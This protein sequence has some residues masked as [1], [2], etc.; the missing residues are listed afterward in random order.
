VALPL[1]RK[2]PLYLSYLFTGDNPLCRAFRTN[3]RA[4]NCIFAFMSISYKKDTRI[5]FSR[6]IQCFQIYGKLFYFQGPLQ[7]AL[8]T[9]PSFIQLF[10]YDP[11]FA[12]NIRAT[13]F[14]RLDRT[15]LLQ[16]TDMLTDCNPFITVYKTARKRLASQQTD[17]RVLLNPQM[18][19]I[20]ESGADRHR[21][22]LPT[23]NEV[24]VLIPDEYTDASCR[25]LVLTVCKAGRKR[26]QMHTVNVIY[27]AYIPLYYVLLFPYGDPGWH[28]ELQLQDRT[29]T[30]QRI[31]LE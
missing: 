11:L 22:N 4:Y 9:E 16:L 14:P 3:I 10:F 27:A 30:R 24:T 1:I 19:L 2:P 21:E 23:S 18:R 29:G 8:Y 20:L 15:V 28:Y 13:N 7:P 6:G 17:F 31:R 5:D 25:N 26:P 12:T